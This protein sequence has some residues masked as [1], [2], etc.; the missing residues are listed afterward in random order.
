MKKKSL[1]L[2]FLTLLSTSWCIGGSHARCSMID[3]FGIF[4]VSMDYLFSNYF[5]DASIMRKIDGKMV[6]YCDEGDGPVLLLL[7]GFTAS[8]HTWN[9]WVKAL[10]G[11]YR[12]IR[13]DIIGFGITGPSKTKTYSRDDWVRFVHNFVNK[14]G[15]DTFSIAGNSLGGYIAWNYANDYPQKVNKLIL[16]DPVGYP[17]DAPLLLNLACF[18]V[19]GEIAKVMIPRIMVK[20]CLNDVYGD[21][22]RVTENLVDIYFDMARR[23]GAKK[24]YIDIFRKMKSA[25][26]RP[27]IGGDII[28]LKKPTFLMWGVK[29]RWVP[30]SLVKR[31]RKDVQ[32]VIVKLYPELGHIPMEENP[33]LTAKDA[34]IFL[35]NQFIK[36]KKLLQDDM[37]Q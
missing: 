7:H 35:S 30:V 10:E 6:H 19:V 2:F 33:C 15:L 34:D 1:L 11:K 3:S 31:W 16:L 36:A 20:L 14:L 23:P 18:P 27:D 29:D 21:K 9:G 4:E 25:G 24:A 12:I 8:L 32:H 13:L 28:N 26:K 37:T 5:L 22:S 17:Q